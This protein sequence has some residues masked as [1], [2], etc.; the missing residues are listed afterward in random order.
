MRTPNTKAGPPDA[1]GARD[2]LKDENERLLNGEN[3]SKKK[4]GTKQERMEV[5]PQGPPDYQRGVIAFSAPSSD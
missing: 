5:A 3:L 1:P 4:P 2:S